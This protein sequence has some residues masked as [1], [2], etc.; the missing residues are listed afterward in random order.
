MS[1]SFPH[2]ATIEWLGVA[3]ILCDLSVRYAGAAREFKTD[4]APCS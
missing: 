3:Q 1:P 4:G 2:T